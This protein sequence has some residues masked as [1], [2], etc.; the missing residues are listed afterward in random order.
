MD[1][2]EIEALLDAAM[3]SWYLTWNTDGDIF[4][5]SH[6]KDEPW[7]ALTLGEARRRGL[8]LAKR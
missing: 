8:A 6:R 3:V 7:E 4:G 1:D 5:P 2:I